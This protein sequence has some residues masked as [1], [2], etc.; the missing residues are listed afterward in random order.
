MKSPNA[1][2]SKIATPCLHERTRIANAGGSVA[3][4]QCDEFP[5]ASSRQG[6][7]DANGHF[8]IRYI[9]TKV[10]GMHG[11]YL[12][13]FYSRYRVGTDN[14]FWVRIIP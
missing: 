7:K 2:R 10:N 8:S 9:P 11:R 1:N 12:S 13:A 14:K 5:Y 4:M 3:G 6:A